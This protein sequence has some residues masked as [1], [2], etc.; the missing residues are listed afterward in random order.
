MGFNKLLSAV[1]PS[2]ARF[3]FY[4][5]CHGFNTLRNVFWNPIH[6]IVF[7]VNSSVVSSTF[8]FL[9]TT[10]KSF[11]FPEMQNRCGFVMSREIAVSPKSK[12]YLNRS[13]A[14]PEESVLLLQ[15]YW[16][17]FDHF[18]TNSMKSCFWMKTIH[19][20]ACLSN[21]LPLLVTPWPSVHPLRR[22][23]ALEILLSSMLNCSDLNFGFCH[24]VFRLLLF[25]FCSNVTC[26][27]RHC[28][29]TENKRLM[30]YDLWLM[31]KA[32]RWVS[33]SRQTL[34]AEIRCSSKS[35]VV[36]PIC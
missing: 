33:G 15:F 9:L 27:P 11:T 7:L 14:R 8:V 35:N 3:T 28:L 34:V 32:M 24:H 22:Q 19:W 36:K 2:A 6:V 29:V 25:I 26:S 13:S 20:G 10:I 21:A 18:L 5:P 1:K 30:T 16:P 23:H 17:T 12:S 31:D 4:L